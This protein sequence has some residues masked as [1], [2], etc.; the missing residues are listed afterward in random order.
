VSRSSEQ[1]APDTGN[2]ATTFVITHPFHP[3]LKK[4]FAIETNHWVMGT[5]WIQFRRTD[6]RLSSIR[7]DWTDLCAPEPFV[8]L[9]AGRAHFKPKDLFQLVELIHSLKKSPKKARRRHNAK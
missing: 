1:T 4:R 3:L 9:S 7:A 5:E 8:T 6:G 2:A